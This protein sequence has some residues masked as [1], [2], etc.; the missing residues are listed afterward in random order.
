M[1]EPNLSHLERD[2][3]AARTKLTNDLSTLRSPST[4]SEFTDSLKQEAVEAKNSLLEQAK[5]NVQSSIE[6]LMEDVKARA[7]ENPA[8][9]LAIGAGIAWRLLRHP[10]V[11]TI[12]V[13]AGLMSLFKTQ[14]AHSYHADYMSHA[15]TRLVEQATDAVD[16]AKEKA[17]SVAEAVSEKVTA[18]TGE[19]TERVEDLAGQATSTAR[20]FARETQQ[21]ASAMWNDKTDALGRAWTA[22]GTQAPVASSRDQMLLGAAGISVIA[23]LGIAC[24]RRIVDQAQVD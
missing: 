12:L 23:A 8:A 19:L 1:S 16:L 11:T 5:T 21:R 9:A 18:T 17:T 20:E 4:I 15:R 13:G 24:Q 22:G 2:V 7:A 10:P 14:P 3:E 6:S